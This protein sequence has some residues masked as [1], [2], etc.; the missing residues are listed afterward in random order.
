MRAVLRCVELGGNS[1][2]LEWLVSGWEGKPLPLGSC[3]ALVAALWLLALLHAVASGPLR[4]PFVAHRPIFS[5]ALLI[6]ALYYFRVRT[7]R[8]RKTYI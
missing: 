1:S 7:K 3:A 5:H 4:P 2:S 6:H 8:I